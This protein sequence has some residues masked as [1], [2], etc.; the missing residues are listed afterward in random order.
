MSRS[1]G[2]VFR[3]VGIEQVKIDPP[4]ME[5]PDL[6]PDF[7]IQNANRNQQRMIALP[8]FA[9]RQMMEVLIQADGVLHAILVDLLAEIAV[10]IKQADRDKVQIEIAGRFAMIAGK[11]SEA[12]GVVRNRF[13]KTE[14]GGKI[15]DRFVQTPRRRRFCRRC[16]FARDIF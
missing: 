7:V 2:A 11:N 10:T 1:S 4:D 6:R 5:L 13:V 15:G 12:A 16:P 3:N 9:D 14:L 8:D